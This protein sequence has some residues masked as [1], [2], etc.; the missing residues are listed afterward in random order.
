M[1]NVYSGPCFS[2]SLWNAALAATELYDR[3]LAPAG[4]A[5]KQY[6]LLANL[7]YLGKANV[8]HWAEQVGID[9]STMV[10]NIRLLQKQGWIEETEGHGKQFTLSPA[11]AEVLSAAKPLWAAAQQEIKELLGNSDCEAI[12]RM[13]DKLQDAAVGLGV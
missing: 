5:V 2:T 13:R 10:R 12:F 6:R 1:T 4:I 7:E 9:R 11:G 3:A 8:T